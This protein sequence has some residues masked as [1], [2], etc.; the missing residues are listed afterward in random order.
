M[1]LINV[2]VC[3]CVE[4][5]LHTVL[6]GLYFTLEHYLCSVCVCVGGVELLLRFVFELS[7][8]RHLYLHLQHPTATQKEYP[9]PTPHHHTHSNMTT[10][11][12]QRLAQKAC[13]TFPAA[14][15]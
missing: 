4:L 11:A 2:R 6:V 13:I 1:L 12:Q 14:P 8:E 7:A 15:T 3:V 5:L 10:L 9:P